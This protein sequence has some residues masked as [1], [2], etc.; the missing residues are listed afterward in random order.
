MEKVK[1]ISRNAQCYSDLF[2]HAYMVCG[3]KALYYQARRAQ[4][5]AESDEQAF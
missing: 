5:L 1:D 2:M 3:V 4:V